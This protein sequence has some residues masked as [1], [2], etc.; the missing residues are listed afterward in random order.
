MSNPLNGRP[1]RR[2]S[3]RTL[4]AIACPTCGEYSERPLTWLHTAPDMDCDKC[5]A[6]IDLK[7]G[8]SRVL[9]ESV[10]TR[11]ERANAE[12]ESL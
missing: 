2:T 1:S 11:V 6:T 8:E 3:G 5:G 7:V 9:I 10:V 12:L 4:L